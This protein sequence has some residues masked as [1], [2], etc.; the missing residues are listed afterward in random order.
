LTVEEGRTL[1]FAPNHPPR[2]RSS[3]L[4]PRSERT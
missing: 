4:R 3:P 2:V 1:K